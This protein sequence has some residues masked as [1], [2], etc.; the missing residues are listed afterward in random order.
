MVWDRN[1]SM[2]RLNKRIEYESPVLQILRYLTHQHMV[3]EQKARK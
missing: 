1:F 2:L 3:F